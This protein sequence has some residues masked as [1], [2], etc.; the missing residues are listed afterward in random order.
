MI[1]PDTRKGFK[2]KLS[3]N[4]ESVKWK[5]V[6]I[7]TATPLVSLIGFNQVLVSI[8]LLSSNI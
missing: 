1:I 5:L 4:P 6:V 7:T 3:L 8:L 2:A